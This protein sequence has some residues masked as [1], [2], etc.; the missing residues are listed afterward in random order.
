[1]KENDLLLAEQEQLTI[2][3]A[4]STVS[5]DTALTALSCNWSLINEDIQL[6]PE[7]TIEMSC[8]I[9]YTE[10]RMMDWKGRIKRILMLVATNY[11]REVMF[12]R[13]MEVYLQIRCS[14]KQVVYLK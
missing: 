14:L 7:F 4:T 2:C 5:S 6:M 10:K 3:Q 11:L 13:Y 9:S 8:S 12:R 1:M